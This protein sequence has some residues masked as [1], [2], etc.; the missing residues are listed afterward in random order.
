MRQVL[1]LRWYTEALVLRA[2]HLN[3]ALGL[4]FTVMFREDLTEMKFRVSMVIGA[5]LFMFGCAS[6]QEILNRSISKAISE[7]ESNEDYYVHPELI[8]E[9]IELSVLQ[10]LNL[11]DAIDKRVKIAVTPEK[12]MRNQSSRTFKK[13]VAHCPDG[14]SVLVGSQSQTILEGHVREFTKHSFRESNSSWYV[15]FQTPA[16]ATFD[17]CLSAICFELVD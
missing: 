12:C 13:I 5:L 15:S 9:A 17:I 16:D 14:Y 1:W 7:Y 8:D 3:K 10:G 2:S 6:N 11:D 4:L